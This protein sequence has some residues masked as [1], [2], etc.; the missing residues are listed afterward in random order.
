MYKEVPEM[1][2]QA[3]LNDGTHY[4]F[5]FARPA[6]NL[7]INGGP[8]IRK[9][10]LDKVG[11]TRLPETIDDWHRVLTKFKN[12]DPNGNGAA[13]EIPVIGRNTPNN[14]FPV[15][16]KV[17]ND[18]H[19]DV[20]TGKVV[21]G[22][23]MP[24]YKDYLATMA[25]W[26]R[27]G[28][29]DRDYITTDAKGHD[30]KMTGDKGGAT[31]GGMNN[32]VGRF[33]TLMAKHGKFDLRGVPWPKA[34]N[35]TSYS[36]NGTFRRFVE[37]GGTAISGKNKHVAFSLKF[38]DYAYGTE[39]NLLNNFGKLGET[40][41]MVNG[42]P[43]FTD[44]VLKNPQGMAA[45]TVLGKYSHVSS[46]VEWS[47]A[48]DPRYATQVRASIPQQVQ[49]EIDWGKSSSDILLPPLAP[50]VDESARVNKI[51]S[52]VRTYVDEMGNK[53]IM[54]IEPV[55]KADEFLPTIRKMGIDEAVQIMQKA[56]DSYQKR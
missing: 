46:G 21:F 9:D 5:P 32:V 14:V 40:Y 2:K 4:L 56:F 35:G 23:V 48:Q 54:G 18:F 7:R 6:L 8:A 15:A 12:G 20:D 43:V 22:P 11:E 34:S 41:T 55:S 1:A 33:N 52:E 26:Y 30:A 29:I 16:W 45:T 10:W 25:S 17:R 39:G 3:V 37:G 31:E 19:I 27:E 50:S 13:D 53:I 49:A 44:L 36:N 28:L 24:G 51:M 42:Q 38:L 47:F